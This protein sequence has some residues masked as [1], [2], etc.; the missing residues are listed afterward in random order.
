M[1]EETTA[2]KTTEEPK[3]ETKPSWQEEMAGE[4]AKLGDDTPTETPAETPA[5]STD[6]GTPKGSGDTPESA[7]VI[8]DQVDETPEVDSAFEE[9][10]EDAPSPDNW[11][12][13]RNLYKDA[14]KE[15]KGLKDGAPSSDVDLSIFGYTSEGQQGVQP[16]QT[17]TPAIQTPVALV[18]PVAPG[19]SMPPQ[20]VFQTL[21]L[22]ESGEESGDKRVAAEVAVSNMSPED[23]LSVISM[24][25][26]NSFGDSSEE[27]MR[28]ARERLPEV[29]ATWDSRKGQQQQVQD[30]QS[31]R[32]ESMKNV[33]R[34]AGM[35]SKDSAEYKAYIAGAEELS[36][37]LPY[38][39]YQPDAPEVVLEYI[40][41]KGQE[42]LA[43]K[44][45][46]ENAELKNRL[47][48]SQSPQ[49]SGEPLS[50]D[51]PTGKWQDEM[52][53][54]LAALGNTQ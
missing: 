27:V 47:G 23:V 25:R 18:Q 30:W 40:R 42:A 21:A 20:E 26:S 15:N 38:L 32:M 3:E 51:E 11:K 10:P 35:Q 43:D 4:I 54:D 50:N 5:P 52:R 41:L 28:I 44:L 16:K 33:A 53:A 45:K 29:S 1:P 48:T 14:K 37:S 34:N 17:G 8:P 24:A 36:Q 22:I 49:S 12:T 31:G 46:R 2:T 7:A 6:R 19:T 39:Q 13:L 9:L